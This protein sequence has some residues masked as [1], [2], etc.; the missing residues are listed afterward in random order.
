MAAAI[1]A[2]SPV[3]GRDALVQ[4]GAVAKGSVLAVAIAF[5]Y[6]LHILSRRRVAAPDRRPPPGFE[7]VVM[8][9]VVIGVFVGPRPSHAWVMPGLEMPP[10]AMR[11][12][13]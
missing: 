13:G 7:V 9:S 2:Y 3:H 8:E 1:A 10:V 12:R 5:L 4:V 6:S 11:G